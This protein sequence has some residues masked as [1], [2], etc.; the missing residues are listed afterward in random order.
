M[1]NNT[2]KKFSFSNFLLWAVLVL[3]VAHLV[4]LLLGV[5]N[6]LTPKCLT[7]EYFNYILAFVLVA[8]C[9]CLYICLMVIESKKKLIIPEWF[10]VVF[11]VGFYVFTNVYYYFGLYGSVAG[12]IVFYVFFAFVLNIIAL[13]VFFNTQKSETNVLK[14]STT[15]T[16]LTT[17]T[18][19][20]SAGAILE[21]LVS[22]V[23][24][25]FFSKTMFATL[26]MMIIEMCVVI[27][28]SIVMAILFS[29]SMIRTK[30][31]INNCL[32]KFYKEPQRNNK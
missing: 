20:V 7:R 6:V 1:K 4:F 14:T 27:L 29:L 24:M 21:V 19:A 28:V 25:I 15:F 30:A 31:L 26:Q 17:F 10:K 32:I 18:Y 23:K 13:A 22:A 3:S 12:L 8:L 9:L 11:Y 2:E 16:T 5:F